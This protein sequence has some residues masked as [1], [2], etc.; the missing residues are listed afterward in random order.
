M[1][2]QFINHAK[3][4]A[5]RNWDAKKLDVLQYGLTRYNLGSIREK[6]ITDDSFSTPNKVRNP[7]LIIGKTVIVEHD[8]VK[9]HGEL[10]FENERTV[11]RNGD[12]VITNRNFIIINED[13]AKE[14]GIDEAKLVV[15]LYYHEIMKINAYKNAGERFG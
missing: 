2:R 14:L 10:G 12:Y 5:G 6:T 7:D 8:T 1:K 9:I 13:L 3:K 4:S 15:Y 11:R